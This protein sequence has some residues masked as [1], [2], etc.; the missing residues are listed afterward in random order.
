MMLKMV[1]V[2]LF[3]F[4]SIPEKG[5]FQCFYFNPDTL[6]LLSTRLRSCE[7]MYDDDDTFI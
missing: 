3:T 5:I 4:F 2:S 1:H 6:P 7:P